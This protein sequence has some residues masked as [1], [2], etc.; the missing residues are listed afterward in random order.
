MA[1]KNVRFPVYMIILLL[2]LSWDHLT[3]SNATSNKQKKP[4]KS[5]PPPPEING[6]S[7]S[8]NTFNV[9]NYGAKGNGIADDTNVRT[10][11]LNVKQNKTK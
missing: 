6:G 8:S 4:A 11:D 9:L 3:C 5:S 2:F 10:A 7:G 1:L